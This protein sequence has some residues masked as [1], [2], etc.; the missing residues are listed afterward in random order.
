VRGAAKLRESAQ[1]TPLK[2]LT[3]RMH[4]FEADFFGVRFAGPFSTFPQTFM[5]IPFCAALAWT[6]GTATFDGLNS[7]AARDV[8]AV[9]PRVEVVADAARA[10]Y[11]PKVIARLQDGRSLEWQDDGVASYS[12]TWDTAVGMT[13]SLCGEAGIDEARAKALIAAVR[14]LDAA[15]GIGA[16]TTAMKNACRNATS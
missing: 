2:A 7:F 3:V 6:S 16:V 14:G 12:L 9:V 1:S 15:S 11:Q 8:L 4:P 13:H 5:S 10:R